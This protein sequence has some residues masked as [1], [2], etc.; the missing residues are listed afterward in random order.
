M[1]ILLVEDSR[2]LREHIRRT[3]EEISNAVIVGEVESE[4]DALRLLGQLAIDVLVL[5]LKLTTGSGLSV[6]EHTKAMYPSIIVVILTNYGQSE[7]RE[8]CLKLGADHFFDKSK[9]FEAFRHCLQGL[10]VA[11]ASSV[12]VAP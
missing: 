6:L 3:V 4:V 9:D 8:K 5:D 10:T 2:V 11:P 12:G 7:Y 1:N